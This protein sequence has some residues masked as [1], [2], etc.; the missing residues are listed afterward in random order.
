MLGVAS[1]ELVHTLQISHLARR[2]DEL[3]GRHALPER[4]HD[5]MVEE[6]FAEV[7]GFREAHERETDLLYRA[8]SEPDPQ[9]KRALVDRA[10]LSGPHTSCRESTRRSTSGSRI[11]RWIVGGTAGRRTRGSPSSC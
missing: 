8:V 6:R 11:R 3:R 7:A 10:L 4:I 9:R 5:D 1:H 2:I